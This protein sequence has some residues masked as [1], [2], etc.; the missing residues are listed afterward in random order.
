MVKIP[1]ISD[2]YSKSDWGPISMPVHTLRDHLRTKDG[3][4]PARQNVR[5]R[6][7]HSSVRG[8]P[9][10]IMTD[11]KKLSGP[12]NAIWKAVHA[13]VTGR[14]GR[15][16][17]LAPEQVE[18]AQ[19]AVL[20][21]QAVEVAAD[22]VAADPV[23]VVPAKVPTVGGEPTLNKAQADRFRRR[24]TKSIPRAPASN[25]KAAGSGMGVVVS[26][27]NSKCASLRPKG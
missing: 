6:P 12:R 9:P 24:M 8:I 7:M 19:G 3:G 25:G 13:S 18:A 17:V 23:V 15:R 2:I 16:A 1:M 22:P 27:K 14:L 26:L 10:T 11:Q 20:E 21:A 5:P 4:N